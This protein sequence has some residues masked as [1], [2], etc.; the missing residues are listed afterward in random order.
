M[1]ITSTEFQQNVGYYLALAEKG[2][3]IHINKLKPIKST[4]ILK[5]TKEKVKKIES[6]IERIIRESKKYQFHGGKETGL[7]I[8]RRVR[9]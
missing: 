9:S 6:N 5:K 1:P 7:E 3:E 4:F 2:E 8:Q